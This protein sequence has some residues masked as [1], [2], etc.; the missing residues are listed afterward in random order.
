MFWLAKGGQ[1]TCSPAYTSIHSSFLW[2]GK[3]NNFLHIC[4]ERKFVTL[5]KW[6]LENDIDRKE[7]HVIVTFIHTA[8]CG[9]SWK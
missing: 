7:Y 5:P 8:E 2:A 6:D 9:Q 3:F 4:S 1:I